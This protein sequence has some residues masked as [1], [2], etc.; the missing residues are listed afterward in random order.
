MAIR[1]IFFI[2]AIIS[3]TILLNSCRTL[4]ESYIIN[5]SSCLFQGKGQAFKLDFNRI[6]K[7]FMLISFGDTLKGKY[8]IFMDTLYLSFS[9]NLLKHKKKNIIRY[10]YEIDK[11]IKFDIRLDLG[12]TYIDL[13]K[14]ENTLIY[15]NDTLIYRN[16][17][18]L[19]SDRKYIKPSYLRIVYLGDNACFNIKKRSNIFNIVLSKVKY[20]P[21]LFPFTET[22]KFLIRHNKLYPIFECSTKKVYMNFYLP[23]KGKKY[24][25]NKQSF[26]DL[27]WHPSFNF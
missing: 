6:N 19:G 4:K 20:F 24:R 10:S 8:N 5:S 22:N 21:Q 11:N 9:N 23:A 25:M 17:S 12:E 15:L 27:I 26:S 16:K 1:K 7:S 2:L 18:F 13:L 3:V 14:D